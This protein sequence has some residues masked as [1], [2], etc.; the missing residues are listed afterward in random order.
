MRSR[1]QTA[2]VAILLAL[3][4]GTL[5]FWRLREMPTYITRDEVFVALTGHSLAAT[6]RD[7]RGQS[8]P[9]VFYHEMTASW[10]S[11]ALLYATALVL[12]VAPLS[13]TSVRA[14]M[15]IAAMVNV[16]LVFFIGRLVLR[17]PWLAA[18][19][20]ALL[21]I[22]PAHVLEQRYAD[23]EALPITFALAATLALL[24]Y[25][26]RGSRGALFAG[27]LILACGSFSYVGAAPLFPIYVVFAF[28]ALM[29]RREPWRPRLTFA[30]GALIPVAAAALWIARHPDAVRTT[31]MHYQSDEN[32]NLAGGQVARNFL[33][34]QH[35]REVAVL[36]VDFWDMQSLFVEGGPTGAHTTGRSGVFLVPIA[37]LLVIGVVRAARRIRTDTAAQLLLGGFL[38]A[39]LP[40][41]FFPDFND[42]LAKHATWRAMTIF[43]F[44][45]LLAGLGLEYVLSPDEAASRR[46]WQLAWWAALLVPVGLTARFWTS[47]NATAL[48]GPLLVPVVAVILAMR[49]R[50]FD[51][52]AAAVGAAIALTVASL[53][54]F[55]EFY[56]DYLGDYRRRFIPHT[57]GN[58]EAVFDAI[59]DRSAVIKPS[60][61]RTAPVIYLGF[62]MGPANWGGYYWRYWVQKRHRDDLLPRTIADEN[63]SRFG[64]Q[65]VCT[66]PPDSLVATPFGYDRQTDG[67]IDRMRRQNDVV[68]ETITR[69][70]TSYWVLRTTGGCS[71]E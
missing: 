41:A 70:D 47:L 19:P 11:P 24:L 23:D 44:G 42:H 27:G 25:V 53:L 50:A 32:Q 33:T 31:V 62:R 38:L 56:R 61:L 43:P 28:I 22:T 10:W 30:A 52:H 6:G 12:K 51:A 60:P 9:L 55:S 29:A 13:E 37:G 1:A 15:A 68:V 18:F 20:A 2:A 3:A 40:A 69:S 39:P 36:Y 7:L 66:L 26:R 35:A 63:A 17:R 4:T 64:R 71:P 58:V 45:A 16:V 65:L 5:C 34:L 67:L 21:A 14:P 49:R 54:Q 46:R 48:V 59:I 57:D 8:M